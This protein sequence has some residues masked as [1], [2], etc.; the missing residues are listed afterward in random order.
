MDS[1]AVRV[2]EFSDFLLIGV[3]VRIPTEHIFSYL[4]VVVFVFF[5]SFFLDSV[6]VCNTNLSCET[7]ACLQLR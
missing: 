3:V 6:A 5:L 7:E 2:V 4:V 1:R